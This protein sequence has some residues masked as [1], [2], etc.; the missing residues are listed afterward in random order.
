[1][2][3]VGPQENWEETKRTPFF[4]ALESEVI[5]AQ[6]AGKSVLIE[7]DANSKLGPGYIPNDPHGMSP[8]GRMLANII[9]NHALVVANGSSKCSGL[10]TRKRTMKHRNEQS[11]IDFV[12][13]SS[14][15]NNQFM[16]LT[17]D[18]ERKNVLTKIK[19]IQSMEL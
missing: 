8:N 7:I 19:K 1:M 10:I 4:I 14:D 18:E 9:E 17:I 11:C 13:F 12:L 5:R 15:L 2:S 6:I 16:S 3:G